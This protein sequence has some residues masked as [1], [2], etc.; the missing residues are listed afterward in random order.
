MPIVCVARRLLRFCI[1]NKWGDTPLL[2][3]QKLKKRC[4]IYQWHGCKGATF[5]SSLT[6]MPLIHQ[7]YL[8]PSL[9]KA[10]PLRPPKGLMCL[11]LLCA[12]PTAP[13]G[14]YAPLYHGRSAG[15][16]IPRPPSWRQGTAG[17]GL[18]SQ[19]QSA[20]HPRALPPACPSAPKGG[21]LIS[22]CL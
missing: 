22:I 18:T 2:Y 14:R 6:S 13:H 21:S 9:A 16:F 7:D 20:P 11:C 17:E 1:Y 10:R 12:L 19:A 4:L 5:A 3:K 15:Y 8:S